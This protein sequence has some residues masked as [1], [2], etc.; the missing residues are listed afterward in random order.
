MTLR[1]KQSRFAQLISQL[2]LWAFDQ[3]YE[4]TLGE[5]WRPDEMQ[6]IYLAQ[7]K[8]KT[9]ASRHQKR[10]AEDLNLFINGEYQTDLEAYRPLGEK[11]K[12]MDRNCVWGGEWGWDANHFQFGK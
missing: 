12:S 11:W 2:I 4:I 5:A 8:T 3:G 10:L 7:G 6:E 9:K 1:Q